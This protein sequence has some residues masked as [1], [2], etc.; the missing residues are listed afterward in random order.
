MNFRCVICQRERPI[1]EGHRLAHY[2]ATIVPDIPSWVCV[3]TAR[4]Y[5]DLEARLPAAALPPLDD[6][7]PHYRP[8]EDPA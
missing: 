8:P 6:D 4:C 2:S 7:P 5:T 1:R 3:D